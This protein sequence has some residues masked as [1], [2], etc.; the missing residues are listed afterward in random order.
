MDATV[1]V[2]RE[3]M[4]TKTQ[5]DLVN[6]NQVVREYAIALKNGNN[7]LAGRIFLA[8][9]DLRERLNKVKAGFGG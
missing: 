2:R 3:V 5:S 4:Y 7:E 9:P 1:A 6:S 8:N